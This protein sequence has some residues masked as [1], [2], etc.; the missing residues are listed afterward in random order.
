MT[1][2]ELKE[3]FGK[4]IQASK[5]ALKKGAEVSK[6]RLTRPEKPPRNSETKAS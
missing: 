3:Y 1:N 4:G 6:T 2:D 5:K